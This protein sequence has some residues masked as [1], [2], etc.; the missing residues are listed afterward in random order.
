MA[1]RALV[2]LPPTLR[3]GEPFE[4]RVTL[5]HPMETGFRP[6]ENGSLLPRN[7]ATRFEA[8]IDGQLAFAADLY[9]AIAANPYLAFWLRTERN[10]T[11]DC[12]WWGD[13]GLAHTERRP[14]VLA[15]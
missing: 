7:I 14:L 1:T 5:Q 13:H 9:P 8:R 11:L 15:G 4:V 12:Q 10:G 3:A 2:Y 6:N